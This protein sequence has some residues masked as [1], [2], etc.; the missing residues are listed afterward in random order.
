MRVLDQ[1]N[2]KWERGTLRLGRVTLTPEWGMRR[3]MM[4]QSYTTKLSDLLSV[5][6]R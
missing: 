1:I 3:E 6:C 2:S 4:N 5:Q